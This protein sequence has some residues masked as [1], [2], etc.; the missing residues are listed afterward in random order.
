M[1]KIY[2]IIIGIVLLFFVALIS[3]PFLFQDKIVALIKETA[4]ENVNANIDFSDASLSLLRNFPKASLKLTDVAVINFEPFKGDTLFYAQDINLKLKLTDLFKVKDGQLNINSFTIDNALVNVMV[5]EQG[6]A[7]YD[8]A[9]EDNTPTETTT[10]DAPSDFKLSVNA[11]AIENA[12]IKYTDKQGKM[13]MVL[14]NFS[15]SGTGDFSQQNVELD[16]KTNTAISFI[17]DKS[18]LIKD[19]HLDLSAVLDMDLANSKFSFLKN[20]AHINQLP[21]IFS[22]FVK[23]N[24]NDQD[25]AL[26]FKTPSSDFKNFLAL[27]PEEY[28]KSIADVK[29]SGNF[30]VVGKVNGK[31]SETTIPKLDIVIA[32]NNASFKYPDLPK[33]VD[34]ININAQI[35]NTTGYLKNTIVSL[36][37]LAFKIDQNEFNGK[38]K[39]EN[40]TE[41][42]FINATVKGTLNLADL[43]KVYPIEM[44]K[45]LSGIIKA[46]LSSSFDMDAVTNNRYER[47]KNNGTLAIDNFLFDGNDVANPI[48]INNATVDFKTEKISLTNFDALTGDSDLKATGSINN[49]L[50]FLLSDKNLEGNFNLNSNT[51]KLSD[52]MTAETVTEETPEGTTETTTGEE[53]L[54]IPAFLDCTINASAK[55]VYYDNLKLEN[56]KGTL[57]LKN[58]KATLKGVNGNMFGGNIA[59]NGEV[60]TQEKTP[61]FDMNLGINSFSIAESFTNIE[62]FKM[63]SPVASI[64]KGT[65][66]TN[67]NLSGDLKDD[68]TPNLA[69]ISGK[70]LAEILAT[71]ISPEDSP[72]L[73]LLDNKLDFIDLKKLDVNDIKTNIT[74]D[75]GKVSVKPFKLKYQDIDISIGG[76]HSIDQVMDYKATFNVPA[77]YL[78]KEVTS[79]LTKL[80]ATNDNMTVPVTANILGNFTSPTVNTDL[81]SAVG[82]LTTQLVQQQK[83]KLINNTVGNLLG[84]KKDDDST[85]SSVSNAISGLLTKK[86]DT[87]TS[88]GN[89]ATTKDKAVEK[90]GDV[91]GGLFGK[92]KK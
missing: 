60:N 82:N 81:K 83:S 13:A 29:T 19:M 1:K 17:M 22:G 7:N 21:L 3:I 28:A 14:S 71:N 25:I 23:L 8:I 30:S 80:D 74:F 43:T 66:N 53:V 48:K 16:T 47:I 57:I 34:N 11:Y 27:I 61:I 54:K 9:K 4:N 18:A 78:G 2:K 41:N 46:N 68:F 58:E 6:K 52:F 84:G 72:A 73:S 69:T 87:T 10:D 12:E 20:E 49:L 36:D 79:L 67:V 37:K 35:K 42:P 39:V 40:I 70:A 77:K 92:K 90:V 44:A 45:E 65:I 89:T 55:E 15:H 56:V 86:K 33:S 63:L 50:G 26:D 75:D 51:F 76:T 91:L 5:D 38:V 32:S 62:M 85:T 31:V 64:L 24:E 59:L 88:N